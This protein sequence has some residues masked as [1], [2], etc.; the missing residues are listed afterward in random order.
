MARS[1]AL[2][3]G[4]CVIRKVRGEEPGTVAI[5]F[6]LDPGVAAN[7]VAVAGD[8]NDWAID[9]DLMERRTDGSFHLTKVLA[10]GKAYRFRYVLDGDRWVNAWDADDYAP[11]H[12]G[13]EDSVVRTDNVGE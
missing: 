3:E 4:G 10:I 13:G 8:F 11:N 1:G 2:E 9:V 6:E 12:F 5:T 7:T